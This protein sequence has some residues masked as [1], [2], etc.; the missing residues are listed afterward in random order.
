MQLNGKTSFRGA[1][2]AVTTALLGTGAVRA[3]GDNRLESSLLLYSEVNRVQAAEGIVGL[4]RALKG[5]RLLNARLTLDGLTG[6]S[7]NGATVSSRVQ[8]FTRPS[9]N[10]SYTVKP[11]EI[12]FDD[13]FKDTRYSFDGSLSQ[14]LNRVTTVLFGAHL[15]TE[16]DYTSLG[17]NI[18]FTR[19]FNRKNTTLSASAAFS[20]DIVRPTGG[21]PDPLSLMAAPSDEN[22]IEREDDEGGHSS[23]P[24]KNKNTIDAV[25]GVTQ[26]LDRR[27]LLRINYSY[28]H[29]SGYLNDPYKLL[30]VV[31]SP[32]AAEPGEPV[33]YIYEARPGSHTRQ[34]LFAEI[35][36]YLGGHTIDLSYRYFWDDWGITSQTVDLFYR[37][38]LMAGHALQPHFRWYRQTE[39]DFYNAFLVDGA[40][41]PAHASADYRLAPFHAV[42]LGLQYL[43]PVAEDIHLSFGFEY[44]RQSGDISPPAS[45]GILSQHNLF[46]DL[47]AVMV[48]LGFTRDF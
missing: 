15:S 29:A 44:Y 21:A 2:M 40:P 30:S 42:T 26:V 34:A 1:L 9:G 28:S 43:L 37:L 12:P 25:L 4:T 20:H 23:G 6:A 11:G 48:R 36:R 22:E 35:R 32:A 5:G 46:P 24:D 41:L 3:A 13:T 33:N 45:F 38:P 19:D 17:A 18:G 8:T 47:D 14:P 27:T 10:G 39:A 16:H 31:Q 7:P